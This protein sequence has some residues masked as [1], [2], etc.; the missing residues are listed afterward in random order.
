MA[1]NDQKIRT[2]IVLSGGMAKGAYQIGFCRALI[3][4]PAFEPAAV[5]AASIGALNGYAL[6]AG[7]IDK[8]ETLWKSI[9]TKGCKNIFEKM[10]RRQQIYRLI[11]SICEKHDAMRT[12][13][14]I[15]CCSP[16]D[17]KAKYIRISDHTYENVREYLKAGVSVPTATK[18]V[19]VNG[20]K[21]Y[22]GAIIDNTPVSPLLNYELD[23]IIIVQFDGHM[24]EFYPNEISCPVLFLNLQNSSK[25]TDSF[26]LGKNRVESMI[27]YGYNTSD[28]ILT[29][30]ESRYGN[31]ERFMKLICYFNSQIKENRRSGDYLVRCLNKAGK[32]LQ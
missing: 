10:F 8:A 31:H 16:A 12:P 27:D 9:D 3:E 22:D 23:L 21:L 29:L 24:P 30:I 17:L 15:V 5:S 6:S 25:F 28:D 19:L 11:D 18:P 4:H 20:E 2:G 26:D 13:V 14:C 7:K 32:L 1:Q